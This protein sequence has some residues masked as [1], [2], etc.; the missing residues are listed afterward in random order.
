MLQS[1][2]QFVHIGEPKK[3][4]ENTKTQNQKTPPKESHKIKFHTQKKN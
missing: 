1:Q 4:P 2:L 3:T